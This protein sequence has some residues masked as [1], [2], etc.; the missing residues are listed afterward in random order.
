[1]PLGRQGTWSRQA[2]LLG[3]SFFDVCL[4]FIV[5]CK[6]SVWPLA[7]LSLFVNDNSSYLLRHF[8]GVNS[9]QNQ[10]GHTIQSIRVSCLRHVFILC[11]S[12]YLS[13]SLNSERVGICDMLF[14]G[15]YILPLAFCVDFVTCAHTFP[16]TFVYFILLSR[17]FH[18][19]HL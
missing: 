18:T 2:L 8:A 13:L 4:L 12:F 15:C 7:F 6:L 16:T 19:W 9:E 17:G 14:A 11:D 10:P 3:C 1:M 5:L